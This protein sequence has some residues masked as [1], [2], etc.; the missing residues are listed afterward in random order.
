M[1]NRQARNQL[2]SEPFVWIGDSHGIYATVHHDESFLVGIGSS[3]A[4]TGL[5]FVQVFAW[6]SS[7][8]S[9]TFLPRAHR[10]RSRTAENVF[11][12]MSRFVV[13]SQ[14]WDSP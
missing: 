3:D 8:A 7:D 5:Y 14:R 10:S 2:A 6:R 13:S 9:A 4:R 11:G 12:P 1:A